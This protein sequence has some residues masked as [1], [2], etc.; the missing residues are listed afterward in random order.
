MNIFQ[1]APK[2]Y[3]V[4]PEYKDWKETW[5]AIYEAEKALVLEKLKEELNNEK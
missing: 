4:T 5:E 1:N 2:P 3:W